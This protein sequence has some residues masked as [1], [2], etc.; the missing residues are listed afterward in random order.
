VPKHP[1]API[2]QYFVSGLDVASSQVVQCVQ[3][4]HADGGSLRMAYADRLDGTNSTAAVG[5]YSG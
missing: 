4:A 2:D 3:S 1:A 5:D